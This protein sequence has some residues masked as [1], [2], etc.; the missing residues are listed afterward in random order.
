[1]PKTGIFCAPTIIELN[2]IEELEEEIFGPVL[3]VAKFKASQL[4]DVI[5]AINA[6]QFGLTFGLHTRMDNR[7]QD[8]IDQIRV[9][10]AYV[11][12]NQIGAVVASQPFGGEGLSGTGP[13]AGG[14]NYVERFY[15]PN[16]HEEP[17]VPEGDAAPVTEI[18]Y[19]I[20][21]LRAD[22]TK[23]AKWAAKDYRFAALKSAYNLPVTF[24]IFLRRDM[25]P[26]EMPGPTGES[27]RLSFAPRGI[28]LV[29]GASEQ[30]ALLQAVAALVAG[31]GVILVGKG[32][33][34]M[35][36]KLAESGAP[37]VG[38]EGILA[39][40]AIGKFEGI[41]AIAYMAD[42]ATLRTVRMAI[43]KRDGAL[44]PLITEANPFRFA[45]ERHVCVDTTAAGGNATLLAAAESGAS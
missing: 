4:K 39:P 31:N 40:D 45:L 41:D 29:V 30:M 9:G 23:R 11:N 1:M 27:N 25:S 42:N 44:L 16:K 14:P 17:A 13:K 43:A 3:H 34:G 21:E 38:F 5:A 32:A 33:K 36:S 12:R 26:R 35:A 28:V 7:V 18:Q 20:H 15:L 8:V 22:K 10:N 24:D 37:I 19:A 2:G 6:K